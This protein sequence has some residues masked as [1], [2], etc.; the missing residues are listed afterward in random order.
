MCTSSNQM[1][2]YVI[3]VLSQDVDNLSDLNASLS[4][5]SGK[6][7]KADLGNITCDVPLCEFC[8]SKNCRFNFWGRTLQ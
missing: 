2:L 4:P 3:P 8:A 7:L 6:F 1:S 5:Y